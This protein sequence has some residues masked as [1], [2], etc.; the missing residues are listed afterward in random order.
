MRVTSLNRVHPNEARNSVP[1]MSVFQ[2]VAFLLASQVPGATSIPGMKDSSAE[3]LAYMQQTAASY[4]VTIK[5]DGKDKPISVRPDPVLRFT[6]PVSGVGD[7]GLFVWEDESQRPVAA[8]QVFIVPNSDNTW[9]HEFQSLATAPMSFEIDGRPAWQPSKP[10]LQFARLK[11]ADTPAASAPARLLQ[12]RRLARR[13]S[14]SD[15]FEGDNE[16]RL[17]LMSTPI[18]R[19]STPSILD[20][21]V[22]VFSHGTDPELFV[23]L[24]TRRNV[25]EDGKDERAWYAALAP[26]TSYALH[27]TLDGKRYWSAEFRTGP[28]P[29]TAT[30]KNFLFPPS[31]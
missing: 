18:S 10:G 8:A 22:F 14:V 16:D 23:V 11:D 4:S 25:D 29:I 30:F 7:G 21:A 1:T 3:R 15:E 27:A 28:F 19:Y 12:M 17:R 5:R 20:G 2:L 31:P 13:F 24:E 9:M 6:N 26:M